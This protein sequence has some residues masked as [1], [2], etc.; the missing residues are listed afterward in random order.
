MIKRRKAKNSTRGLYIQDK[1][2]KE[3]DFHVGSK[4]NYTLDLVNRKVIIHPAQVSNNT[5]SKRTVNGEL[6]PVIDLR[7]K[8]AL[9]VFQ[10]AEH[11]EVEIFQDQI[12]V[13]GYVTETETT[14]QKVTKSLRNVFN[15][16]SKV[17]DLASK[18]A[19]KKSFEVTLSKEQLQQVSGDASFEQLTIFDILDDTRGYTDSS[20]NFIKKAFEGLKIPLQLISLFSGAG[21]MDTGFIEEGFDVTFALEMDEEAVQT[22]RHNLGDH[23]RHADITKTDKEVFRKIGAPVVIGGPP[24]QGFSNSNRHT[25]F[26]D[27]PNNLLLKEFIAS[28]KANESCQVFVIENVP[29]IL[30]AGGGRFRDEIYR[31]LSEFEISSGV[32]SS[33]QFGEAQDRKRAFF[34]GSKIGR[35]DL[36]KP[37]HAPG[38]FTSVRQ[39]FKGLNDNTPNQTDISRP[40]ASTEERMR[41]V[42]QGENWRALPEH[43]KTAGMHTGKTHSS[44]YRRLK[45]DAPAITITN[46][47]KS[48]II[49]PTENRILSVRECARLFGIADDFLFKGSLSSM[50]QQICNSVPVKLTRAIAREVKNAIQ[51]FNIRNGTES[52]GLI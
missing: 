41:H 51:R 34:I 46:P 35:I 16:K 29:Q 42:P 27:N 50:Q 37:T 24:C 18:R 47:R 39:A 52:F 9:A 30:T 20:K 31:E 38:D 36:P 6:K 25:N 7:D 48:N 11:L 3:T 40:R 14:V 1:E 23:I 26:L 12:H 21:I 32:L 17:I 10:D 45:W 28:I 19:Y 15:K 43:L 33:V 5:V 44:I 49:H 8:K 4:F 22:Y 13:T 2:L